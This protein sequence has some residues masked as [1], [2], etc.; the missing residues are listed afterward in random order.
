MNLRHLQFSAR[1][2]I[3][4]SVCPLQ[5]SNQSLGD[6]IKKAPQR[7]FA[8][9]FLPNFRVN[10]RARFASKPLF[11]FFWG[12]GGEGSALE[13]LRKF[14]GTVRAFF[15]LWGS[16]LALESPKLLCDFQ[17]LS[18]KELGLSPGCHNGFVE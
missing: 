14:F 1:I 15:G 3:S 12:G 2:C 7:T 9:K 11:F 17:A 8:T 5:S 13:S 4:T 10:F 16:F 6:R 18:L